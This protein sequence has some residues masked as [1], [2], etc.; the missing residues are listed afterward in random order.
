MDTISMGK[1]NKF[2]TLLEHNDIDIAM[3]AY[4]YHIA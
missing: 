2:T 3:I 1:P 4:R